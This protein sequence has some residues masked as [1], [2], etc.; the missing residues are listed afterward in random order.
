MMGTS[1]LPIT[2]PFSVALVWAAV[3]LC[4][5][6]AGLALPIGLPRVA[7]E[8]GEKDGETLRILG[9]NT[10]IELGRITGIEVGDVANDFSADLT[11]GRGAPGLS[12]YSAIAGDAVEG[13]V[14]SSVES[15][16]N[17][18]WGRY[19]QPAH[20]GRDSVA[21]VGDNRDRFA[22]VADDLRDMPNALTNA[23]HGPL[24]D[25][26]S[27]QMR[28]PSERSDVAGP[29]NRSNGSVGGSTSVPVTAVPEPT[30]LT[31][32]GV[33]LLGAVVLTRRRDR[34]RTERA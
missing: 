27:G 26:G 3:L 4:V 7:L 24:A 21:A 29:G 12:G 25:R 30:T 20:G 6:T 33:G 31:L 22:I 13:A 28:G 32:L 8:D 11:T 9:S 18:G 1:R 14:E 19:S 2:W 5:P 10:G 34:R 23:E 15:P 17:D 16:D